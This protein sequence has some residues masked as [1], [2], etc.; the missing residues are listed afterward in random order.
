MD[1]M[2]F[3]RT[4]KAIGLEKLDNQSRRDMLGKFT[5]AGGEVKKERSLH[6]ETGPQAGSGSG[7][8][9]PSQ[10]AREQIRLEAERRAK[11]RVRL[12]EEDRRAGSFLARFFLKLRCR[13]Q[14]LSPFGAAEVL[15]GFMSRLNLNLKRALM[16]CHIL[17]RELFSMEGSVAN[18]ILKE[19]DQKH[20]LYAELI[21]RAALMYGTSVRCT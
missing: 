6:E 13:L 16:E 18:Q 17:G 15:P 20:P 10:L 1:E 2:E 8:M 3:D 4:R 21:S 11:M 5:S 19:L 7:A 9:L 12:V 14:G